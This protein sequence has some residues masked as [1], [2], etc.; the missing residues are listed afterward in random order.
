SSAPRHARTRREAEGARR[1]PGPLRLASPP[2]YLRRRWSNDATAAIRIERPVAAVGEPP[3][4]Q[5]DARDGPV[6]S[7]TVS[8][9]ARRT[10]GYSASSNA[11]STVRRILYWPGSSATK[12]GVAPSR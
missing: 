7:I 3:N 8:Y 6:A 11:S 5:P 9:W 2:C 1:P 10:S 12:L 4:E